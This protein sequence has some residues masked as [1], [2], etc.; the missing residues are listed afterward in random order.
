[1]PHNPKDHPQTHDTFGRRFTEP[2]E[3]GPVPGVVN[4]VIGE[5]KA[6]THLI[7]L[8]DDATSL[9]IDLEADPRPALQAEIETFEP[10]AASLAYYVWYDAYTSGS[11]FEQ[12][13]HAIQD[14]L[15]AAGVGYEAW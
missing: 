15:D 5:T 12:V 14:A 4:I 11:T 13:R 6:G 7:S 10:Y 9:Q 2:L 1:L 3:G 8:Q